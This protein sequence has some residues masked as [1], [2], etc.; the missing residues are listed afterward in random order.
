MKKRFQT[1]YTVVLYTFSLTILLYI[2][3]ICI[4]AAKEPITSALNLNDKQF[5][6]VLSAFAL[7]YALFQTPSG[8]LL[9]KKGPRTVITMIVSAW[10]LLTALTGL[11]WNFISLL[12]IRFLFG[13]GEAGAFPG[14]SKSSIS[15]FPV[16]GS[17]C[18]SFIC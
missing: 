18:L 3:R 2:D 12:V 1:R 16:L 9:D 6:W 4:S 7:G 10:S 5:G 8:L 14:I 13:A 15:W 11:A 17:S